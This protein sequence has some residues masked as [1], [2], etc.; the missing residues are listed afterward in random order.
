MIHVS[1]KHIDK[2][3][4]D[5]IIANET[6]ES[7]TLDYKDRLPGENRDEKKEFLADVS[8]MANAAGGDIV[9]GIAERRVDGK[10]TGIPER[11][12]GLGGVN[13]DAECLRIENVL[14]DGIEPRINGLQLW[15]VH[16]F[17]GG[18]VLVLRVP[19]S[20]LAPHMVKSGESRFYSRNSKGKYPLDVAEIRSA[21]ALSE[22]IPEKIRRFRDER[23]ARIV[24]GETPVPLSDGPKTVLHLLP[25][26]ALDPT[27]RIE[28]SPLKYKSSDFAPISAHHLLSWG[29]RFNLDGVVVTGQTGKPL[30]PVSYLQLF[31]N[32]AVE[33]VD[34]TL[35][36]S[37][38][39]RES[40]LDPVISVSPFE[41]ILIVA[42]NRILRLRDVV[43]FEPPVVVMLSLVGV[44]GYRLV[45]PD[46]MSD[47]ESEHQVD[48]DRMSDSESEHQ[49]DR[50]TLFLPEYV[51][52]DFEVP[53]DKLLQPAFDAMWQCVGYE[54]DYLFQESGKGR[55][56]YRSDG[57][58]PI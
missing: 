41:N 47:S 48:R 34:T 6:S 50:D 58:P 54:R 9:F 21:F 56:S 16:G 17:E 28:V 4:I 39:E 7:R 57:E 5:A 8:A 31:R 38:H 45:L 1:L 29:A 15:A 18:P 42:L 25:L 43:E 20:F 33:A 24:A 52:L 11:V 53:A 37:Q 22:S 44:R 23:V 12:A 27:T 51:M 2:T 35:L 13:L 32:G 3:V 46:R 30:S 26:T 10:P 36:R 40:G 49:V 19:K 55:W 14:R